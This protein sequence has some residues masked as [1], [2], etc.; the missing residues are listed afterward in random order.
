[1][2]EFPKKEADIFDLGSRLMD[3]LLRGRLIF[4]DPPVSSFCIYMRLLNFNACHQGALKAR[5][6]AETAQSA[7]DKA[8]ADLVEA[9]K[10]NL[11]YAENITNFQ[12]DKLKLLGWSDRGTATPLPAPGQ[13]G[14]LWI[15]KQGPGWITLI[16]ESARSGGKPKAYTVHRRSGSGGWSA[17]HTAI[18]TEATL[19]DQ[20]RGVPLEYRVV[21]VNKAGTSEPGNTVSV[22][23]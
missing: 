20:P 12:D 22:V 3:G 6:L 14:L 7:K 18:V 10:A 15:A 13:P 21:A 17:V 5:S 9:M 23:L 8:L 2:P 11:R 16:W 19:A 1:M 4:P